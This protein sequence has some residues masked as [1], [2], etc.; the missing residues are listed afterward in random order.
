MTIKLKALTAVSAVALLAAG[1]A[2]AENP[3]DGAGLT[4]QQT[5]QQYQQEHQ[6]GAGI[7]MDNDQAQVHGMRGA[8][9][10]SL[11]PVVRNPGDAN[12][13]AA[14]RDVLVLS[15]LR[16]ASDIIGE[17]VINEHGENVANVDDI[18]I[19]QQGRAQ[20]LILRD[21]GVFGMGGRLVSV[22]YAMMTQ[23]T[24]QGDVV[25]PVTENML[26]QAREFEHRDNGGIFGDDRQQT[27]MTTGTARTGQQ[28]TAQQQN[29]GW[30]GDDDRQVMRAPAGTMRTSQ[31]MGADVIAADGERLGRVDDIVFRNGEASEVIVSYGGILGLARQMVAMPFDQVQMVQDP[32]N[33]DQ[34]RFQLDQ[35]QA[36]AF[37]QHRQRT[38]R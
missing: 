33:R 1:P 35:Q 22:D 30:M 27:G 38:N 9:E 6:T 36:S 15:E 25:V 13:D 26:D 7:R 23:Q 2:L 28:Q 10:F 11:R 16:N 19:D 3:R 32:D 14:A 20:L 5:Q 37:S 31:L 4:Q 24:P 29:G 8:G 12:G 17:N 34:V 18:I 21:G